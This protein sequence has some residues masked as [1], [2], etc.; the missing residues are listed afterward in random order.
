MTEINI[1]RKKRPVW[2]WIVGLLVII[3]LIWLLSEAF[4]NDREEIDNTDKTEMQENHDRN[5]ATTP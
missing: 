4:D 2:P 5:P 3:A 1:Q